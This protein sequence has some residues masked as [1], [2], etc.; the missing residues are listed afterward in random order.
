M[1]NNTVYDYNQKP[2]AQAFVIYQQPGG[3]LFEPMQALKCGTIFPALSMPY[4]FWR[5][6]KNGQK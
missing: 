3:D 4:T 6:K 5:F 1:D 2:Y